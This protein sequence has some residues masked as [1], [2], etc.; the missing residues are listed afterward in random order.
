MIAKA[1]RVHFVREELSV[2]KMG[3]DERGEGGVRGLMGD[4][5]IAR[6]K[7]SRGDC[8]P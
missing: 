4:K 7:P 5:K 3:F 8:A 1:L 2:K 6:S